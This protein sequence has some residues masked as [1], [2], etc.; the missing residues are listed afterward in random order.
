MNT[1]ESKRNYVKPAMQVYEMRQQYRI[2]VG[3]EGSQAK[4]RSAAMSV[5]YDE[6]DI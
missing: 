1:K 4:S 5:T 3:S 2:L 6:E